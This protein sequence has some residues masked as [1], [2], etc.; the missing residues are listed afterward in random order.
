MPKAADRFP[1]RTDAE[2]L[3]GAAPPPRPGAARWVVVIGALVIVIGPLLGGGLPR[4]RARWLI[5]SALEEWLNNNLPAALAR[6]DE[7]ANVAPDYPRVYALRSQWRIFAEDYDGALA[8][9]QRLLELAPSDVN[10]FR[11]KADALVY[12]GRRKEAAATWIGYAAR[13]KEKTGV[14]TAATLNGVAYFRALA[15]ADLE[16]ALTDVNRA[17]E[18]QGPNPAFL[19]TRGYILFLQKKYAAAL[20]D[21]DPAVSAVEK[22]VQQARSVAKMATRMSVTDSREIAWE[23]K[24]VDRNLA[25]IRYHRGLLLEAMGRTADAQKDFRR[26]R[27][28]GHEPGPDLF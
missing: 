12:A 6:L 11:L 7:A 16:S 9:A 19:D 13:E 3:E 17:I 22:E 25:V 18:I 15:N 23:L 2:A 28:L 27:E 10:G 8:D 4:E 14:I 20:Q 26:V 24:L 1:S 5:A 21:M